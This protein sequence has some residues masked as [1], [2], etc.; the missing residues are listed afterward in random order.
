[1]NHDYTT[2]YVLDRTP[3]FS[4]APTI[5]M[6]AVN[7]RVVFIR[8]ALAPLA[9]F[10]KSPEQAYLDASLKGAGVP[11]PVTVVSPSNVAAGYIGSKVELAFTVDSKGKPT[12][13]SVVS[14]PDAVLAKVI[15]DAVS[16][17]RYTPAQE[18]G[19][20]VPTKVVLPVKISEAGDR[21][22]AK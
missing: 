14:A 16:K 3:D 11:V 18:N 8:V 13:M 5:T 7:Q 9:A 22:A 10:A 2:R 20:A 17:W 12:E 6:N 1:M 4:N 21:F 15:V 19:A